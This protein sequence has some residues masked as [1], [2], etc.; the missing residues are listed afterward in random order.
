MVAMC[1][2]YI[3]KMPHDGE[4]TKYT[5]IMRMVSGGNC[6]NRGKD[7]LNGFAFA[8]EMDD[9]EALKALM[10]PEQRNV[11]LTPRDYIFQKRSASFFRKD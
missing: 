11:G 5:R 6:T 4:R 9:I 7:I 10:C 1:W 8:N 3:R 2:M